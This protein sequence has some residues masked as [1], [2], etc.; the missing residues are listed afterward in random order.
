MAGESR[1][2][3]VGPRVFFD[4][5]DCLVSPRD[6]RFDAFIEAECIQA[7]GTPMDAVL[8]ATQTLKKDD[9]K[10][11]L[12]AVAALTQAV[13][14]ELRVWRT[15]SEYEQRMFLDSP[16]GQAATLWY[17]LRDNFDK[18]WSVN[19]VR[20]VL[21]ESMRLALNGGA[22]VIRAWSE[23]KNG[24]FAAIDQASG[25]DLLGN[26][27]GLRLPVVTEAQ[28]PASTSADS[29]T[30]TDTPPTKSDG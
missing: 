5:R 6:N 3:G 20:F 29:A 18:D 1:A 2:L 12:E 27:T 4:G 7:R 23:W 19:R 28:P 21:G 17:C 24:L 9:G 11:D 16:A 14:A 30:S 8:K 26:L 25:D 10:P 15:C 13:V 22:D